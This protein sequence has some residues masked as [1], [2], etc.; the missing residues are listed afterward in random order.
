MQKFVVIYAASR[1]PDA[2]DKVTIREPWVLAQI[3]MPPTY[4]GNIM[5]LLYDH[6]ASVIDTEVFM[7]I[8]KKDF[9]KYSL[10]IL[11]KPTHII[12][13]V[14]CIV[15]LFFFTAVSNAQSYF[16]VWMNRLDHNIITTRN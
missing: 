15:S 8:E 14:H 4:M 7:R 3:I 2:G 5:N 12:A 6:E 16:F 13:A 10:V 9:F 1:F 11:K